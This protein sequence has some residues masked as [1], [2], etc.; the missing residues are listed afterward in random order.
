MNIYRALKYRNCKLFFPGLLL[1]QIGIWYQNIAISWIVFEITKSPFLMGKIVF[2]NSIPLFL[3]I[4]IAGVIT[5]KYNKHRLLIII[6]IL[7]IT[8]ALILLL[9]SFLG[10]LNITN[11][12]FLGLFL[13]CI[14]AIDTPLR[15]SIF[16]SLIDDKKD[17]SNA[18]ALNSACFNASRLIGPAIAGFILTKY[19]ANTCFLINFLLVVP[20]VILVSLLKINKSSI[21]AENK[22]T[23]FQEF[24]KGIIYIKEEKNISSI[25]IALFFIS[26]TGMT[27]P[28]LMP[29]Y[30]KNIFAANADLLGY[31]MGATG[32]GALCSS[33]ILA[34]KTSLKELKLTMLCGLFIFG[35]SFILTGYSHL[36][37]FSII[38]AFALGAGMTASITGINTIIQNIVQ[39][40]KRGRI[41]SMYTICYL[42]AAAFSNLI[43][44]IISEYLGISNAFILFG[45]IL[46][47]ISLILYRKL[48]NLQ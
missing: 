21:P 28:V 46:I 10:N 44:G 19:T 43:A 24:K 40:N 17:L 39:D 20:A 4:P 23:I 36:K 34:S 29:I 42:G 16:A 32:L 37:V 15:Q 14:I 9:T 5:D 12:I 6:Q 3:L 8:Q 48:K 22:L 26:L 41:M 13:N 47:I 35:F 1:S 11:I 7:F 38:T 2:I 33:F 18:I 25:L 27:Y 30:T 45:G 31:L